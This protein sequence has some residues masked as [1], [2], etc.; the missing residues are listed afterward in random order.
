MGSTYEIILIDDDP[1]DIELFNIALED[2]PFKVRFLPFKECTEALNAFDLDKSQQ[3]P[4]YI[5]LDMHMP[6]IDGL[7][8]LEML[9]MHPIFKEVPIIIYTHAIDLYMKMKLSTVKTVN[10]FAKPLKINELTNFLFSILK[11]S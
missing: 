9:N 2:L 3:I 1:E 4:D 7:K 6:K 11:K 8:C 5:F 10:F